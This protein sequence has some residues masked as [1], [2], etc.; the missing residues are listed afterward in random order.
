VNERVIDFDPEFFS[1]SDME[2]TSLT[3]PS[4]FNNKLSFL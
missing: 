2:I 3:P 4:F 1:L